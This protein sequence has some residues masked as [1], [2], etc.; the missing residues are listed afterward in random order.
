MN[1]GVR[2]QRGKKPSVLLGYLTRQN[3]RK[4]KRVTVT[5][6]ERA[7]TFTPFFTLKNPIRP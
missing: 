1:K 5:P 3:S 7:N 4:G 2:T 6:G